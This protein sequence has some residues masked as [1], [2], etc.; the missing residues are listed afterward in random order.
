[1][2]V[3]KNFG[4]SIAKNKALILQEPYARSG[5][6]SWTITMKKIHT[7]C[8][9]NRFDNLSDMEN[10]CCP[11]WEKNLNEKKKKK[12]QCSPITVRFNSFLSCGMKNWYLFNLNEY[13]FE[14][15]AQAINSGREREKNW[16]N[17]TKK[18]VLMENCMEFRW[19]ITGIIIY[20][21]VFHMYH[22]RLTTSKELGLDIRFSKL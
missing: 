2:G 3:E 19:Q 7:N 14:C 10:Y 15:G 16:S 22:R 5:L 13:C 9:S 12:T 20:H 18:C 21:F 1:M 11:K 8:E 4:I 6:C 17:V